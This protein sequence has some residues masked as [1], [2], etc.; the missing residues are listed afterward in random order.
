M[1]QEKKNTNTWGITNISTFIVNASSSSTVYHA[2]ESFLPAPL[3]AQAVLY[4]QS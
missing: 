2:N 1:K 4:L 3:S